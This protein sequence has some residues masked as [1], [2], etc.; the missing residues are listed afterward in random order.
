MKKVYDIVSSLKKD[1]YDYNASVVEL[2]DA[3]LL[4]LQSDR[5]DG[6]EKI[7][8]NKRLDK[9]IENIGAIIGDN[10]AIEHTR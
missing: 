2:R 7:L 10:G 3:A 5:K 1:L 4:V 6:K 8:L 9:A